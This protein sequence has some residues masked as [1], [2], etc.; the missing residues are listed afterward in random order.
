MSSVRGVE[1]RGCGEDTQMGKPNDCLLFITASCASE[2]TSLS[3]CCF[4]ALRAARLLQHKCIPSKCGF[5][6]GLLRQIGGSKCGFLAALTVLQTEK[7]YGNGQIGRNCAFLDVAPLPIVLLAT[8][9][10][11]AGPCVQFWFFGVRIGR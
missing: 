4:A 11:P 6:G 10:G 3:L 7:T 8:L 9:V 2:E 1:K 5:F